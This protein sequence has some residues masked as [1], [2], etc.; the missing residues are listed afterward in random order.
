MLRSIPSEPRRELLQ[1]KAYEWLADQGAAPLFPMFRRA[2]IGR[3]H[4]R[5]KQGPH[6]SYFQVP[7]RRADMGFRPGL[8]P[9]E[10]QLNDINQ[11]ESF[12][13]AIIAMKMFFASPA[14]IA[15]LIGLK[16][17]LWANAPASTSL[18]LGLTTSQAV[19][20]DE[21]VNREPCLAD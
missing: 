21:P 14:V 9:S 5:L 13:A 17:A 3:H 19:S 4:A 7:V 10:P 15:A 20:R 8:V 6:H 12:I 1:Y 11:C 18:R 2:Q 16:P